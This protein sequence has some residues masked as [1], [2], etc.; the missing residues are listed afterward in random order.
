MESDFLNISIQVS[1]AMLL[2]ALFFAL[3]RLVKGPTIN[4]RIASLDLVASIV[5]GFILLFSVLYEEIVYFDLAII[6]SLVTFVGTV[7]IST[8]L[9]QKN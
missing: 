7:A 8:Y 1:L 5:I 6:I 2:L 9:I 3:V 4:D